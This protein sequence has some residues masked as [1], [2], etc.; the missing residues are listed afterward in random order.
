MGKTKETSL[1]GQ[2][3]EQILFSDVWPINIEMRGQTN[4]FARQ[5]FCVESTDE[6]KK[7]CFFE[8]HFALTIRMCDRT[9]SQLPVDGK[10]GGRM[11][12]S[13]ANCFDDTRDE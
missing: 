11:E 6:E 8:K 3:N 10:W 12:N 7:C 13:S 1:F 2:I 5:M 9:S 4:R